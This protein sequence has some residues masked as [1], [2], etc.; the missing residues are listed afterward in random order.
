MAVAELDANN[1]KP[2]ADMVSRGTG[3]L[4]EIAPIEGGKFAVYQNN[5]LVSGKGYTLKQVKDQYLSPISQAYDAQRAA[6]V[7][8]ERK[9]QSDVLKDDLK[10]SRDITLEQA[11]GAMAQKGWTEGKEATNADGQ[12]VE[13]WYSKT[14]PNGRIRTIRMRIA[15]DREENGLVV[16]GGV[17]V[18]EVSTA[19]LK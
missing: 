7:E 19:G 3:M 6:M 13:R 15:P 1:P 11:K 16:K 14:D 12:I 9:F 2:F 8:E 5:R 10:L 17:T 18:E 4:V